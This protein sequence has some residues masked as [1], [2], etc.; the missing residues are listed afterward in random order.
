M[1]LTKWTEQVLDRLKWKAIVEIAKTVSE[2]QCRRRNR[3]GRS[4]RKRRRRRRKKRR[5]KGRR[6]RRWRNRRR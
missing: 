3:R 1:K 5:R 6:M 2:L 4:R